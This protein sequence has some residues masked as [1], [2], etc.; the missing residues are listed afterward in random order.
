M[1]SGFSRKFCPSEGQTAHF[2]GQ[3][4]QKPVRGKPGQS[5]S[6]QPLLD[7]LIQREL[8][9]LRLLATGTSNLEIA[10]VLVVASGTVK[11]HASHILSKLG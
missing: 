4:P 3:L 5:S 9:V 1:R 8:E 7:L 6:E 11:L 2:V 10:R